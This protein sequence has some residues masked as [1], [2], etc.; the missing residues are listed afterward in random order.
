MSNK[1]ELA[2]VMAR[3]LAR[4]SS[5][6]EESN[7]A[8]DDS[9]HSGGE[10]SN[11]ADNKNIEIVSSPTSGTAKNFFKLKEQELMTRRL[12]QDQEELL[13]RD[14]EDAKKES[15]A[16]AEKKKAFAERMAVFNSKK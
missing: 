12:S 6:D 15:L 7:T 8:I 2:A 16:K 3:R 13:K 4:A 10:C 9:P 5:Q 1:G 14:K 11:T